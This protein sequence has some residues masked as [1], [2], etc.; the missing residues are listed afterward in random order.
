VN[1]GTMILVGGGV[2]LIAAAYGIAHAFV[3]NRLMNVP[4]RD[5][6]EMPL[7]DLE[8]LAAKP[9]HELPPLWLSLLPIVLPV[10]LIGQQ[11]TLEIL[12]KDPP[13]S[14][15]AYVGKIPDW[16]VT[17]VN[18]LGEKNVAVACGLVVGLILLTRQTGQTLGQLRDRVGAALAAGGVIILITAAGGAF[19]KT[20]EQ[21]GVASLLKDMPTLGPAALLSV[22]FV[23]TTAIRTAQ[24]SA[25]VAMITAVGLFRGIELPF[26]P[27]WLAVAIGCGSKPFSWMTDSGFWVI[28]K[29]SGMTETETLE[30]LTPMTA[31]MGLVGLAATI[32]GAILFPMK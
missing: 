11:A 1:V 7:A 29:M 12:L 17:A 20:I 27:V 21:T 14:L 3:V 26:H 18:T 5:T 23:V 31:M 2:G 32:G 10:W 9:D 19:G 25:T 28:C 4:L 22:A 6:V 16:F 8:R 24:G 30:S 13:A 15:A